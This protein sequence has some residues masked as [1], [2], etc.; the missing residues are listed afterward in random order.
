MILKQVGMVLAMFVLMVGIARAENTVWVNASTPTL[1]VSKSGMTYKFETSKTTW[2][3]K[4]GEQ[5]P[6]HLQTEP[7]KVLR[8]GV[9]PS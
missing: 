8:A 1:K 6:A 3:V 9:K 7:G 2:F 5:L 4:Q